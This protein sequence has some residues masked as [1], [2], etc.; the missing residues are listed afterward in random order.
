M[1]SHDLNYED[2]INSKRRLEFYG[3]DE[4]CAFKYFVR[5]DDPQKMFVWGVLLINITCFVIITICYAYINLVTLDS[6]RAA[7]EESVERQE[8]TQRKIALIILTDFVCWIP[9]T[10][11]C[12]L[13]SLEV[14][15]GSQ[16]Y[17]FFSLAILPIN[18]VVNP[19]LFGNSI[20]RPFF[21]LYEKLFRRLTS[22]S[23]GNNS[24]IQLEVEVIE[25]EQFQSTVPTID[26][27]PVD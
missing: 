20:T 10:F 15:D 8:R 11:I 14:L 2:L 16:W 12:I 7:G 18:S 19:I 4:V 22:C 21:L 13:H 25:M 5:S 1:F 27:V 24:E 17:S 3:N 6:A 26:A 23:K 9:F